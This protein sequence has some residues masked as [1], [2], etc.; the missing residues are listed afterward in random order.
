MID[1]EVI[2]NH[3]TTPVSYALRVRPRSLFT[4]AELFAEIAAEVALDEATVQAV[5]DGAR[6]V[7]TRRL[8]EGDSIHLPG[9][10]IFSPRI[11][12]RLD[13]PTDPLTAEALKGVNVAADIEQINAIKE[14]GHFNRIESSSQAPHLLTVT[15]LGGANLALL[16]AGNL[17]QVEG[18]RLAV[19]PDQPDEGAF[20]VPSAGTAVRMTAY[21]AKG[22]KTL[23]FFVNAGLPASTS[24]ALEI[25]NRRGV[26]GPLYTTRWTTFTLHTAP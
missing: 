17:V 16:T 20:L 2:P 3:L 12:Q 22:E 15:G 9:L 5:L 19:Q 24:F 23:Q 1:Y 26:T 25:R 7:T 11:A 6:R 18:E 13:S 8:L 10:A 21:L 4:A 14:Q